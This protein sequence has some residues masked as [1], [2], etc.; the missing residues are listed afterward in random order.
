M[1]IKGMYDFI[2]KR[3]GLVV[4]QHLCNYLSTKDLSEV[5]SLPCAVVFGLDHLI[6]LKAGH[7]PHSPRLP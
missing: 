7:R 3:A 1:S 2:I 4:M 5:K 6:G